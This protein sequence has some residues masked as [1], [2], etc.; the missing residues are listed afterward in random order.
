MIMRS[1]LLGLL[2]VLAMLLSACAQAAPS[3]P[4]PGN[5]PA[6]ENPL[7]SD[8]PPV[9][10]PVDPDDVVTG[11]DKPGD[12]TPPAN[13]WD[14]QPE[15]KF[16]ERGNVFINARDLLIME[17]FPPQY[18]LSLEGDLP[19]PCNLLRV[20]VAEPDAQG[21]IAVEAYSVV[22]P[23]VACI[24]MLSPFSVSIPLGS[25]ETGQYTVLLNGE[26]V[27]QIGE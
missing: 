9:F 27:G 26:K 10:E 5:T 1:N 19:T 14:P 6:G 4:L 16:L 3:E 2:L 8:T 21:Q 25:F 17:S 23:N 13:D 18:A 20:I 22:D 15:D 7:P 11:P 24:Q 12:A